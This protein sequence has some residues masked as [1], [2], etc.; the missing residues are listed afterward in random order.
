MFWLYIGVGITK[1]I[2]PEPS[3]SVACV[4]TTS[5][6]NAGA[7]R[8]DLHGV[9]RGAVQPLCGGERMRAAPHSRSAA[10]HAPR[11]SAPRQ[12][13]TPRLRATQRQRCHLLIIIVLLLAKNVMPILYRPVIDFDTSHGATVDDSVLV[14]LSLL[15]RHFGNWMVCS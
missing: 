13:Y 15:S 5:A 1:P 8:G 10:S 14:S 9:S 3:V 11:H 6:D 4:S 7:R 2:G 12:Q